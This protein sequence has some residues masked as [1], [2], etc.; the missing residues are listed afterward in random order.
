MS[1]ELIEKEE[2]Y[3]VGNPTEF[4]HMRYSCMS[5]C[6]PMVVDNPPESIMA[7]TEYDK[8]ALSIDGVVV[9]IDEAP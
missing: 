7:Y 4:A 3:Q 9:L 2:E 5:I 1:Q 8:T 6:E